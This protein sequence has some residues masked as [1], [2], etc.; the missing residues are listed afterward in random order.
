M[1]NFIRTTKTKTGLRVKA[2]LDRRDYP[3]GPTVSDECLAAVYIT[4]LDP[5]PHWNY[6]I[7]PGM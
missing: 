5:L 6:T 7:D 3:R 1:L 4:Y 2:Y